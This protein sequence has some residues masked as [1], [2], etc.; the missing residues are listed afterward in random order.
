MSERVLAINP[1]STSTK[2]AVFDGETELL[3][4]VAEHDDDDLRRFERVYD[5][6]AYRTECVLDVLHRRSVGTDSLVAVV[7][8][9]GLVKPIPGGTYRVDQAML[10]DLRTAERGEHASNLGAVIADL[11]AGPLGIPA[12]VV[13]PVAVDEMEP[14]ARI[15]GMPELPR[16][17]LSHALNSKAVAREAAAQ[18]QR[19]YDG[20]NLLVVHLGSGV[21]VTPHR[22]GKMIDV[23]N[24]Q[25]EGPFSPDR[26]GGLPARALA[27]LCFSGRF[28]KE[29]LIKRIMGFGGMYAYLGTRDLREAEARADSGD[30]HA[31]LVLDA[32]VYQI[33]KEVGAMATVL[34][35]DVDR[36]VLSGGMAHSD[37]LVDGITERV[38]FIA[39]V[40]VI[41]GEREMRA[42]VA[43]ALRVLRGE[44]LP[45]DYAEVESPC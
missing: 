32:M 8:R 39:P 1:G 30:A 26:A 44:E 14:V 11:I 18:L 22:R 43:G 42:L 17:S 15:S 36:I 24:A 7:G 13:D 37:R 45:Q 29:E 19:P 9:G 35:G 34:S 21:S 33:A 3:S 23:N 20:V 2:V 12:Y 5:Q 38:R 31:E 10:D 27:S 6:A 25:E 41:P 28:T 40:V 4:V 16:Q